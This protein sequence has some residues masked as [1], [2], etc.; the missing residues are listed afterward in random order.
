MEYKAD[1]KELKKIMV[2]KDI[3]T[4][5]EL[6][7]I[8]GINRNTLGNILNGN[9]QPSADSMYKLIEALEIDARKAGEIFFTQHLRDA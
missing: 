4:V 1:T 6:S 9:I 7:E 8:S 2:E 3:N 5:R